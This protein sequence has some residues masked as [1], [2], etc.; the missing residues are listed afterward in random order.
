MQIAEW[1]YPST[2]NLKR[3]RKVNQV[4]EDQRQ[5]SELKQF[6]RQHLSYSKPAI[7]EKIAMIRSHHHSTIMHNLNDVDVAQTIVKPPIAAAIRIKTI[8]QCQLV[9]GLVVAHHARANGLA[10]QL[11]T[12][13]QP[14][15]LKGESYVFAV[16]ELTTFYQT[17]GFRQNQII[18]NDIQQL[19]NKYNSDEKPL[20]LM[21][22]MT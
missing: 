4:S 12:L 14:E 5:W 9:T 22:K 17:H 8:G 13:I 18:D 21:K 1:F 6:Y 2:L 20:I 11:M 10:H 15:L 19:F 7:S 3:D 16:P